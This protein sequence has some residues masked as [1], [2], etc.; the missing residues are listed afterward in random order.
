LGDWLANGGLLLTTRN[1]KT[2]FDIHYRPPGDKGRDQALILVLRG[3]ADEMAWPVSPDGRWFLYTSDE[4]AGGVREVYVAAFPGAGHRR[5][6]STNGADVV[7]WNPNGKEIL[8]SNRR[9]LMAAAV[10]AEGDG[11]EVDAPRVLFEMP[12]DCSSFENACFDVA[13]DGQRFLVLEPTGPPPPVAL[14]QNWT[15]G[16]KK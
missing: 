14:I 10:R 9:K 5:Q 6:V 12:G 16:L 4:S 13:P 15:A 2:G 11:I 3:N 1:P 8:Y 7:R